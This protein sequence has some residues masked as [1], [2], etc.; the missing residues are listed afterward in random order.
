MI[1]G[2]KVHFV[3]SDPRPFPELIL[4]SVSTIRD[5]SSKFGVR[6]IAFSV[7]VN[8]D[9]VRW[10]LG[11]VRED[12]LVDCHTRLR[13]SEGSSMAN[14]EYFRKGIEVYLFLRVWIDK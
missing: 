9:E 5:L 3:N 12:S 7:C 4:S 10:N 11:T 8:R 14:F 6:R 2:V 1:I 13:I